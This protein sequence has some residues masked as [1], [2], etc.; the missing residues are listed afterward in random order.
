MISC[1]NCGNIYYSGKICKCGYNPEAR[2]ENP[3]M[4]QKRYCSFRPTSGFNTCQNLGTATYGFPSDKHYPDVFC[5]WH[6]LNYHDR[7][8]AEDIDAF[9]KW[10]LNNF[11]DQIHNSAAYWERCQGNYAKFDLRNPHGSKSEIDL[12]DRNQILGIKFLQNA[13]KLFAKMQE[14]YP[15]IAILIEEKPEKEQKGQTKTT[16]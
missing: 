15:E 14:K 11:P 8:G 16:G 12:T 2:F 5:S 9:A 7:K 13:P 10:F 6:F 3:P 4:A 1:P